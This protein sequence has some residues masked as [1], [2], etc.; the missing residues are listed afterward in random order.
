M[1][2]KNHASEIEKAFELDSGSVK[3]LRDFIFEGTKA[4]RTVTV[5]TMPADEDFETI[6]IK[7]VK[8]L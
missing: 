2:L 3:H 5:Y 1:I 4:G 6:E 7:S 8:G